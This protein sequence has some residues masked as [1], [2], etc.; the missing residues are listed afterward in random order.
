MNGAGPEARAPYIG[1]RPFETGDR[2]LFFGR[3]REAH[4]VSSL[5][6]AN[7]FL[8]LYA[9]SGSGKTSLVNAGV[10]PLVAGKLEVLPMARFQ[11]RGP[12]AIP[13]VANIYTYAVLSGWAEPDDL[14]RLGQTTLAGFLAGRPRQTRPAAVP[15]PRLLVF[16]QFEELFTTNP[17]HWPERR[18]FLDQLTEASNSDPDLRVLIV[19]RE[20]FMSR[21]LGFYD[22]LHRG[23]KNR[24]FLEPLRRPA[25]ELAISRPL[26]GTGRSFGPGAIDDLV[27]RLMTS[28]VDIGGTSII[29]VQGEFVEPVLLQVVCQTLWSVL[30][31]G[32]TIISRQDV[33]EL[34]D[35]DTSLARFYSDAV[36]KAA[37]L[38]KVTEAQIR[39][40]F[41]ENLLTHPG[42]TRA[43]VY[44]GA[45][46]TAGMPNEVVSLLE[47]TLLRGEFRAGARWL[48]ITHDSLLR[49]IERSNADFFRATYAA[50]DTA[51]T[52]R[53][54]M[55]A[56]AVRDQ[57]TSAA[58]ETGLQPEPIPL[59]WKWKSQLFAKPSATG[60]GPRHFSP[61]PG[62]PGAGG[63]RSGEGGLSDLLALY[64]GL[65]SGRV[66][67]VGAPGSGKTATGM[68]L[69][70]SALTH[71]EQVSSRDRPFVPVPV[72]FSLNG[73]DPYT[74]RI[75][76]W[77][78]ARLR[79][80]Y[81]MFQAKQGPAQAAELVR[82]GKVAA[83]LDGFDEIPA[84]LR[85]TALQA[86]SH[87]AV[88]RV[89]LL[90]RTQEMASAAKQSFLDGAAEIELQGIDATTVTD[91]LASSQLDPSQAGWQEL[92]ARLR[93]DP[94]GPLAGALS[95][96]GT[97]A[98]VRDSFRSGDDVRELLAL[99]DAAGAGLRGAAVEDLL[100][101]RLLPAAYAPHPGE[102]TPR[103]ELQTAARAL[104][105]LATRMSLD[106]TRDLAWWRI[107]AWTAR[108][109][110][111]I[112]TGLVLGALFG[113]V[114][115]VAAGPLF[116]LAFGI[117]SG[118]V[119]AGVFAVVDGRRRGSR[120]PVR[121]VPPRR[122][123]LAVGAWLVGG[124]AF[125]LVFGLG[126]RLVFGPVHS[127]VFRLVGGLAFGLVLGLVVALA[128]PGYRVT[129]LNPRAFWQQN[130]A[131]GLIAGLS[132]GLI[133][134]LLGGLVFGAA[135][136]LVAGLGAGAAVVLTSFPDTWTA[137]V[138]FAQLALGQRTP[139]RLI[140]FLEDARERNVLRSVGP[141]YQFRQPR[142]QDRLAGQGADRT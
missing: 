127:L 73:W 107:R 16:D 4:E 26:E 1:P 89:V 17:D 139:V 40:W 111:V 90:A 66:V 3:D 29:E 6:F 76:G 34:A 85:P 72:M 63:G 129:P 88:F 137:S 113:V 33:I 125:G 35:V 74:Q 48:E 114:A 71:R 94:Y 109:P 84:E 91:Y 101:D 116:G 110:Q 69:L 95:N 128:Q 44:V 30:P 118:L 57:W 51:L 77:L 105:Y 58:F 59:R 60:T 130:R 28:R 12:G 106:G 46:T 42:G 119:F 67:I 117:G 23:L 15:V 38:G 10:L 9:E 104:G 78:T 49:P 75:D 136:G 20:D 134:G 142:L 27:Q 124:L 8:L 61:L 103:Y 39:E 2:D 37:A 93:R 97:L 120:S 123:R 133:G 45:A 13:D 36:Q 98:L 138:A 70:L 96:P 31:P 24:Y 82:L 83:I 141:V 11:T 56:A 50:A 121:L 131:Q 87:Q 135:G 80:A 81:P 53:T 22:T 68:L 64:G 92:T 14:S 21:L 62:V 43:A 99:I 47:G 102:A 25:A 18:E 19:M 32:A 55:L 41:G 7:K 115:G 108:G 126:G 52:K 5:V 100:L 86:L 122:R 65:G 112:V 79:Q 132:G 54:D 140:R